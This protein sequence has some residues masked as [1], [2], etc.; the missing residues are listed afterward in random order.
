MVNPVI[1]GEVEYGI[2]L[3]RAGCLRKRKRLEQWLAAG[4]E[5]L[6]VLDFDRA[7]ASRWARLLADLRRT[8]RS[9]AISR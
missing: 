6:T 4:V 5:R 3:L 9:M 1:L 2:R 7:T 8:G